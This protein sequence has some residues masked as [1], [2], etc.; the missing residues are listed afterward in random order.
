MVSLLS[1]S[2]QAAPPLPGASALARSYADE[3]TDL[4]GL[5]ADVLLK[6]G[7]Y[8]HDIRHRL[9]SAMACF[10]IVAMRT[11]LIWVRK[12]LRS[13][14]EATMAAG[15]QFFNTANFLGSL[16]DL[17]MAEEIIN[18]H[19]LS[20]T[21]LYYCYGCVYMTLAVSTDDDEYDHKSSIMLRASYQQAY[22][23]K[24]YRTMHWAFDNLVS[25]YRVRESIDSLAPEAAIMYRLKEPE[26][27]RRKVS[28]LI[29]EGA[30]AQEKE[31]YDKA[32]AKYNELIQTIPQDLEN[33]RYMA[34][35]YLK[36][37]RVERLMQNP[38]VALET[39]KEALRLTY[40]YEIADVRSSV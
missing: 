26:M 18:R 14:W 16:E 34:S 27:W 9:D 3:Y 29:Y 24:D 2:L 10:S 20:K 35:A 17:Q 12:M 39:L 11:R 1:A 28:L 13:V 31:D 33:G 8:Y 23:E 21:L 5:P 7:A 22:K 40:R 36:R 15:R 4:N 32:L 37:S 30:L 25:V 6:K 38:E 19:N